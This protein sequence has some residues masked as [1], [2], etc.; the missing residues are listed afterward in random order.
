MEEGAD[1]K[2][3]NIPAAPQLQFRDE[4]RQTVELI[5][6]IEKVERAADKR[7]RMKARLRQEHSIKKKP[8]QAVQPGASE[9][10]AGEAT[11]P[12]A[13]TRLLFTDDTSVKPLKKHGQGIVSS[14][15]N[16]EIDQQI[17]EDED[18]NFIRRER[19][20]GSYSRSFR[21]KDI[22]TEQITAKY[23]NGVLTVT[24]PKRRE[25]VP[26]TRQ[27]PIL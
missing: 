4:D 26:A 27:I 15:V 12:P 7:D 13:A 20:C 19:S 17:A 14:M 21:L 10:A 8:V 18:S 2:E 16:A 5:K 24:L 6:P 11:A 22:D 23:E 9:R 25:E 3:K 1:V